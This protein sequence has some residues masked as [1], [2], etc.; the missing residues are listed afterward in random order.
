MS[1]KLFDEMFCMQERLNIQVS[2]QDWKEKNCPWSTAIWVECAE[3]L[4]TTDWKWWKNTEFDHD[5]FFAEL[6]DIWHFGMSQMMMIWK[7]LEGE[8][9]ALI[10]HVSDLYDRV[11][12]STVIKV[13]LVMHIERIALYALGGSFNLPEFFQLMKKTDFTVQDLYLR[14]VAKHALNQFRQE[15]GYGTKG[16]RW[17]TTQDNAHLEDIIKYVN[18]HLDGVI[19]QIDHMDAGSEDLNRFIKTKLGN[20]YPGKEQSCNTEGG[21]VD[22]PGIT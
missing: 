20:K 16:Y 19:N 3:L 5:K 6:V 4:E 15:N 21:H 18:N 8:R 2:G 9:I 14:Y 10:S 7:E 22:N 1:F 13:D 12:K 17:T 11:D